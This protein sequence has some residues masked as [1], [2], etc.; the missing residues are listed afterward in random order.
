MIASVIQSQFGTALNWPLGAALS[1]V[2]LV[3]VLAIISAGDRLER[4][5]R[6]NLG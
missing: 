6:L 1:I 5:G 4:T 3:V 2:V